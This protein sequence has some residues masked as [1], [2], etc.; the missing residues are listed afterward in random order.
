MM[1]I[2]L[3]LITVNNVSIFCCLHRVELLLGEQ[4]VEIILLIKLLSID[5]VYEDINHIAVE[6]LQCVAPWLTHACMQKF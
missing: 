6:L 1:L 4:L 5:H 3:G 2:E